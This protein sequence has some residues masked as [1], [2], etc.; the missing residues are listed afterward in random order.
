MNATHRQTFDTIPWLVNGRVSDDERRALDAHMRE[1]AECR[2]ELASQ[3]QLHAA[4]NAAGPRVDYAPGASLQKLWTR[5]GD[6]TPVEESGSEVVAKS[7]VTHVNFV[8]PGRSRLV[9]WLAAA[10]VVEAVG[11]TLLAAMSLGKPALVASVTPDFKTVTTTEVVPTSA[12]LRVVFAPNFSVADLNA[13]LVREHLEIVSG[14]SKTG[15]FTLAIPSSAAELPNV[16]PH[17]VANLKASGAVLAE[18][19]YLPTGSKQ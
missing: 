7:S 15:Y 6:S 17:I 19:V 3:E 4:M 18:P 5:I 10:V 16:L 1:C 2:S 11:I 14:P 12:A 8:R 9:Q 13:L